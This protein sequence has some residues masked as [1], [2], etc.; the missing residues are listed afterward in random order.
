MV[1][2]V[3]IMLIVCRLCCILSAVMCLVAMPTIVRILSS[4]YDSY[5]FLG[6]FCRLSTFV[7]SKPYM[8]AS[9]S[10]VGEL[11]YLLLLLLRP[12]NTTG[13]IIKGISTVEKVLFSC[14]C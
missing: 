4:G 12:I 1:Y 7:R 8:K 2:N 6:C 3:I 13:K 10:C 14:V 9:G 11:I 5:L